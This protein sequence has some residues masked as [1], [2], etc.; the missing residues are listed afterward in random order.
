MNLISKEISRAEPE[1]MS[2]HPLPQIKTL[3]ATVQHANIPKTYKAR[4]PLQPY[5]SET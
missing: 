2:I 1:Y 4:F 3:F 5:R